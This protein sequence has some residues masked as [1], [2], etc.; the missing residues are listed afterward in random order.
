M[1]DLS[2]LTAIG[3]VIGLL[4]LNAGPSAAR[5]AA[6]PTSGSF[7]L[8]A[9]RQRSADPTALFCALRCAA[10]CGR[11]PAQVRRRPRPPPG[12]GPIS[13]GMATNG[14]PECDS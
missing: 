8:T 7:V 11:R 2:L 12:P 4:A 5:A 13:N 10:V 6:L 14:R 3:L 1:P 9:S